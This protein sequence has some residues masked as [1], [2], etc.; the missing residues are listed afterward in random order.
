MGERDT[1]FAQHEAEPRCFIELVAQVVSMTHEIGGGDNFA[2]VHYPND[3]IECGHD[4]KD[5]IIEATVVL[6]DTPQNKSYHLKRLVLYTQSA[7]GPSKEDYFQKV[8]ALEL[9]NTVLL[10]IDTAGIKEYSPGFW[11]ELKSDYYEEDIAWEYMGDPQLVRLR[12]EIRQ[13]HSNGFTPESELVNLKF[14][15][16]KVIT[17]PSA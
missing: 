17:P 9:G 4:W 1:R 11:G 3:D 5:Y 15:S 14:V 6:T 8:K 12:E 2:W 16:V 10:T 13:I 7:Y